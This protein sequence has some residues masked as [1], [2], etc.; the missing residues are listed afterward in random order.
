MDPGG[1]PET[2]RS[3]S[4]SGTLEFSPMFLLLFPGKEEG[5]GVHTIKPAFLDKLFNLTVGSERIALKV[6]IFFL[7]ETSAVTRSGCRLYD[8]SEF[9]PG[10][11][12]KTVGS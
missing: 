2:Y 6:R 11:W 9:K 5:A 4:G 8:E 3:R 1:G 10:L 12:P 7:L